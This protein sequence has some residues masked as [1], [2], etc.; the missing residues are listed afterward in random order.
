MREESRVRSALIVA[1]VGRIIPAALSMFV[2][3]SG[4]RG[5]GVAPCGGP[6]SNQPPQFSQAPARAESFHAGLR[7]IWLTIPTVAF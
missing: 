5:N 6:W 2:V 3:A 7:M 1:V 4:G